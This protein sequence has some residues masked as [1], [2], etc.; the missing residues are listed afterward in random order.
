[1]DYEKETWCMLLMLLYVFLI[2]KGF[3]QPVFQILKLCFYK[4]YH[5]R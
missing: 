1:M 4:Y 3:S 2:A 5:L